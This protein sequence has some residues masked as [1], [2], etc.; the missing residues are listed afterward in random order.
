MA[1]INDGSRNQ[2]AE[3][4]ELAGDLDEQVSYM[5]TKLEEVQE[6]LSQLTA[7]YPDSLC[8]GAT[9]CA[10]I[11]SNSFSVLDRRLLSFT[12]MFHFGYFAGFLRFWSGGN[13][14]DHRDEDDDANEKMIG[15]GDNR[16]GQNKDDDECDI[17]DF[18]DH[19]LY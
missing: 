12:C 7:L 9:D 13:H 3:L 10:V 4:F 18:S 14:D 19:F 16:T 1:V 5:M 11:A 2:V 8:Y 6:T 15:H 17:C